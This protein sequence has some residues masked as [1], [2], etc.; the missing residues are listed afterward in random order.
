MGLCS[1]RIIVFHKRTVKDIWYF[2]SIGQSA[3]NVFSNVNDISITLQFPKRIQLR[4]P[5]EIKTA[6][7]RVCSFTVRK[8]LDILIAVKIFIVLNINFNIKKRV[9]TS[10]SCRRNRSVWTFL[11]ILAH[12]IFVSGYRWRKI[13]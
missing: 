12:K 7:Y 5:N 9:A 3:T 2:W 10:K 1:I 4:S 8:E 13:T 11:I 6:F